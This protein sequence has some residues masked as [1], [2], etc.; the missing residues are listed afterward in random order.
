[1]NNLKFEF[2][3]FHA[4][5]HGTGFSLAYLFLEN[6]ENCSKLIRTDTI[7]AFLIRAF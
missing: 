2:Y 5:V 1:M 7:A 6:N 3:D 4:E